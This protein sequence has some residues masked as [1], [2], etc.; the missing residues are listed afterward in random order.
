MRPKRSGALVFQSKTGNHRQDIAPGTGNARMRPRFRRMRRSPDKHQT[1][2]GE[3]IIYE[4]RYR[5]I[6]AC[7]RISTYLHKGPQTRIN[8]GIF[9]KS[10]S[11]IYM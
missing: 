8:V 9:E 3:V 7:F 10:A 5:R 6:P 1:F 11:R 4:I 2:E